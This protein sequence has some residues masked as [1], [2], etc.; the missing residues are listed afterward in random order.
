MTR[1]CYDTHVHTGESSACG[2]IPGRQAARLYKAAGYHGIV[3]TD[4][5]TRKFFRHCAGRTWD[6]K[7]DSFLAGYREAR[8]E[9]RKTGLQ[10]FLGAEL[11][12]D[13][14]YNDYLLFGI[15]EDF[16]REYP[17]LYKLEI[18]DLYELAEK[19]GF[20]VYQAHPFR[21]GFS[22]ADPAFLH[23][24][25]VFNG[26]P[27]H[28]SHNRPAYHF[29]KKHRLKMISG[30]DFHQKTDVGRGGITTARQVNTPEE[31]LRVLKDEDYELITTSGRPFST[32]RLFTDFFDLL[33]SRSRR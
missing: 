32:A 1:Y 17:E 9:G 18:M 6:E 2:R 26:N 4:H 21:P 23:G 24:V 5:Y 30:S 13:N 20:L 22:P 16:L 28:D 19:H 15:T 12:L 3:I 7:L 8:R 33:R 29:A 31:L 25:E 11:A 14:P 27:R 10:V